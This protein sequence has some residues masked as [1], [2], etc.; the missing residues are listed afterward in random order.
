ML[1]WP[2]PDQGTHQ[3]AHKAHKTKTDKKVRA[4]SH[5]PVEHHDVLTVTPAPAASGT[6]AA[7]AT[8]TTTE[9][10][11]VHDV[12][13]VYF[14]PDEKASFPGGEKA[15]DEFLHQNLEYPE[16]A[17]DRYVEGTVHAVVT[18]DEQGN[19]TKVDFPGKQL[20]YGIEEEARRILM[21]TPRWNPAKHAGVGVKSK[22]A[23]PITFDI[24]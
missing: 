4:D 14:R 7:P 22:F 5:T 24:E 18:L 23:V 21:M 6:E 11:V 1:C 9:V 2:A 17:V 13:K 16:E 12:E 19:I 3:V 20:G 10:I 15:F 8:G